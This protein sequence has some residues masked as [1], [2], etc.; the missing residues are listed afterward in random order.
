MIEVLP[1]KIE[2]TM[3]VNPTG[4]NSKA[5]SVEK[6]DKQKEFVTELEH[7]LGQVQH[8]KPLSNDHSAG[9]AV[10]FLDEDRGLIR[11]RAWHPRR[12]GRRA[13]SR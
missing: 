4:T 8:A 9:G 2:A 11:R 6:P 5:A 3:G 7:I 1:G 10:S 12:T 13:A